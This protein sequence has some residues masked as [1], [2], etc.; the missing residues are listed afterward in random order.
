MPE[1]YNLVTAELF[2]ETLNLPL[3][4]VNLIKNL[5]ELVPVLIIDSSYSP[6]LSCFI[7]VVILQL[8]SSAIVP[9]KGSDT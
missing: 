3:E 8:L 2:A 1:V 7:Q 5:F 6:P 4:L 9:P